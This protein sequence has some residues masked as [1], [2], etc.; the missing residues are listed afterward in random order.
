M[1]SV[2][3]GSALDIVQ[4]CRVPRFLFVD[5]PLGNPCGKPWDTSMQQRI[6]A[7]GLALLGRATKPETT[8]YSD[9]RWGSDDW[10]GAYMEVND[11]NRSALQKM[12]EALRAD[13]KVREPRTFD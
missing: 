6:V 12:G 1:P 3:V 9:E 7:H 5:F 2:I 4:R 11:Q 13:R 8:E 10:K